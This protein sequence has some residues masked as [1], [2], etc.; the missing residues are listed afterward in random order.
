[1]NS[2]PDLEAAAVFLVGCG[3]IGCEVLKILS[4]CSPKRL[5]LIDMD[6][7]EQSNLNRQFIF[8]Q[9]D[10]GLSKAKQ[11]LEYARSHANASELYAYDESV[12]NPDK[13]S[14]SFFAQFDYVIN[15]LDNLAARSYVA[16]MCH[17]AVTVLIDAGTSGLRGNTAVYFPRNSPF[18]G[19][20]GHECFFCTAK[21]TSTTALPICTLKARPTKPEHCVAFARMLCTQTFLSS[22]T[23]DEATELTEYLSFSSFDAYRGKLPSEEGG[24]YAEFIDMFIAEAGYVFTFAHSSALADNKAVQKRYPFDALYPS[25]EAEFAAFAEGVL[26]LCGRPSS[27]A[28]AEDIQPETKLRATSSSVEDSLE[29]LR[30]SFCPEADEFSTECLSLFSAF[31]LYLL[32][33]FQITLD[34]ALCAPDTYSGY[35]KS[36][37][38]SVLLLSA[39]SALRALCFDIK[40]LSSVFEYNA[41]GG[42]IVPAVSYTN[43][44]VAALSIRCINNLSSCTRA[45]PSD[46]LRH[47]LFYV[48][49]AQRTLIGDSLDSWSPHCSVCSE[50][51]LYVFPASGNPDPDFGHVSFSSLLYGIEPV[52]RGI[53]SARS[54]DLQ[55]LDIIHNGS[56]LFSRAAEPSS[57]WDTASASD[58]DPE[59][60]ERNAPDPLIGAYLN[61]LLY[62]SSNSMHIWLVVSSSA[63]LR[64]R[65]DP[66]GLQTCS[67][68]DCYCFGSWCLSQ[69]LAPEGGASD[70][71][72]T[73]H[74]NGTGT[75]V[76]DLDPSIHSE[77]SV[78]IIEYP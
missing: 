63:S 15:A 60:R 55:S 61:T 56:I 36:H 13:F 5:V 62:A 67:G 6:T 22:L 35:E 73:E 37:R 46:S 23:T 65:L 64:A 28:L 38:W 7:I 68:H 47:D 20:T 58:C 14:V 59:P 32:A 43:A 16:R 19:L 29:S 48:S 77:S 75:P 11:C 33:A 17:Y 21:H 30:L 24:C 12:I 76:T 39:F 71:S 40:P 53:S 66:V 42:A 72:A 26:R 52:L 44:L 8:T 1:M 2:L 50:G 18:P 51:V 41:I 78:L 45:P 54:I 69:S 49:P 9:K 3:G 27:P 34:G 4:H 57:D 10:I 25:V 74:E 31:R 70:G